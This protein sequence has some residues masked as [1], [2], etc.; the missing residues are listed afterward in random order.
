MAKEEK[1]SV[2]WKDPTLW[3]AV[4]FIGLIAI[5]QLTKIW[6]DHYFIDVLQNPHGRIK[7]IPGVIEICMEYNRGIAFS[8]F[9]GA[10]M[11]W[12]IVIVVGT[13][14]LMCGLTFLFFKLDK[15]RG[16]L[17][18]ALVFIVAGGVG[19]LI[20]R[21]M[22]RVWDPATAT[23]I[24]D[25]VRDMVRLKLIFDFGVCNFADFFIVAGAVMLALAMLFFDADAVFPMTKKYKALAK[26]YE[27][28][29]ERKKAKKAAQKAGVELD[30]RAEENAEE[31]VSEI[32]VE[33]TES[34]ETAEETDG[35]NHG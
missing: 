5:D 3:L 34:I 13:A 30:E 24:R 35:E 29:E 27:E 10:S 2:W 19:N 7:I 26:E 22:Y 18:I 20:D 14:L 12:K 8:S 21:I 16:L 25:G 4:L 17:R 15:R 9:S 6:A 32:A 11:G 1:K 28:K 23:G 31:R 33:E